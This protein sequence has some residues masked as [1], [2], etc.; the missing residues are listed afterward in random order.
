MQNMITIHG[1]FDLFF[2]YWDVVSRQEIE[3]EFLKLIASPE[4][5]TTDPINEHKILSQYVHLYDDGH[6]NVQGGRPFDATKTLP[7]QLDHDK[8]GYPVI[9]SGISTID[10][11]VKLIAADGKPIKDVYDEIAPYVSGP[12]PGGH[13]V[14]IGFDFLSYSA[15]KEITIETFGGDTMTIPTEF[16]PLGASPRLSSS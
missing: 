16:G 8:D 10:E 5:L 9:L 3:D 6:A 14:G 13:L 15:P 4:A 1:V 7:Y 11:P 12:T 2:P